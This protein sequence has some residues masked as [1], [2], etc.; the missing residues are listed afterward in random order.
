MNFVRQEKVDGC[1]VA[2]YA[3]LIGMSYDAA[4]G[5][6]HPEP[7]ES[8][9]TSNEVLLQKLT[10]AGFTIM[11]K[12][13]RPLSELRNAVLVV[14]YE[15]GGSMFMHTVV[16][17]AEHQTVLDPYDARPLAEYQEGLCMAFEAT[18]RDPSSD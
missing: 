10:D 8:H 11:P 17:D 7:S 5:V 4:L 6:L 15:I 13:R 3:M 1:A 9:E 16:W 14:R 2:C 12:T 18:R